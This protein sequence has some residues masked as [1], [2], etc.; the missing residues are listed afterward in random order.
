[1]LLALLACAPAPDRS[2]LLPSHVSVTVRFEDGGVGTV[3]AELSGP[4]QPPTVRVSERPLVFRDGRPTEETPRASETHAA[5]PG[6]GFTVERVDDAVQLALPKRDEPVVLVDGVAEVL[7]VGILRQVDADATNEAFHS[8]HALHAAPR[9]ARIDGDLS[10]WDGKAAALDSFSE[11]HAGAAAW[12]GPRDASRAVATRVHH[13][14][15][16]MGLRI[17]DEELRYGEDRVEVLVGSERVAI[18]VGEAG[19]CEVPEGW[20]CSFVEAVEFGTGLELS[21][22]DERDPP[23][24]HVLP[25]VV[26]YVDVDADGVTELSSAPSLEAVERYG[27]QRPGPSGSPAKSRMPTRTMP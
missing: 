15:I 1:M 17:R 25:A 26:R 22:P 12:E 24:E 20:E 10:E 5:G 7:E 16:S 6:Q 9:A 3:L 8:V 11:S 14:R 21:M 2:E 18:P 4:D 13:R 19:T 23:G 27:V